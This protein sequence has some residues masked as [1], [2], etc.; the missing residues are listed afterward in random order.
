MI[1]ESLAKLKS[2][3]E[4]TAAGDPAKKAELLR[5]LGDLTAEMRRLDASHAEKTGSVAAFASAAAHEVARRTP[6]PELTRL[7]IEGLAGSAKEF[8]ATHPRLAGLAA[9]LCRALSS[10]GI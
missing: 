4:K 9:E 1:E 5:L 6:S 10:L 2:A 7:A 3:V 8:E